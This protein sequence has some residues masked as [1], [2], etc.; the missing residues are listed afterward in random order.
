MTTLRRFAWAFGAIGA[1]LTMGFLARLWL[2]GGIDGR[3]QLLAVAGALA[4][5]L[6]AWL[7][8]ETLQDVAADRSVQLGGGAAL[9]T[10]LAGGVYVAT[11]AAVRQVDQ[12]VDLSRGD[13]RSLRDHS[14]QVA[15]AVDRDL[16]MFGFFPHGSAQQ[17]SFLDL[18]E[19]YR[20]LN[21]RIAVRLVDPLREPRVAEANDVAVEGG[22]VL[23][24]TADREERLGNRYDEAALTNALRRLTVDEDVEVCWSVGH[25]EL[26]VDADRDPDAASFAVVALE[27]QA[28]AVREVSTLSG[29]VPDSCRVF[30]VMGPQTA[31]Q[32]EEAALLQDFLANG[33]RAL[34]AFEPGSDGTA[35]LVDALRPFG[36]EVG[37]DPV[38]DPH[39]ARRLATSEDP[40]VQVLRR[41]AWTPHAISR[42]LAGAVLLRI[43]APVTALE[44]VPGMAT[45]GLLWTSERA[46]VEVDGP[47]EVAP[48]DHETVGSHSVVAVAEVSKPAQVAG[49]QVTSDQ[50]RLVVVG[51]TAFATNRFS[52]FGSSQELFLNT[53]AWLADEDALLG[54]RATNNDQ[55]LAIS[56]AEELML[57]VF[58]V[59]VGPGIALA[60]ALRSRMQRRAPARGRTP[61][62]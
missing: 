51:D 62:P 10:L 14:A 57:G 31:W 53:L 6:Y 33:G 27:G 43:A 26:D 8:G 34:L 17:A 52:E 35:S 9:L 1:A 45:R 41:E 36:I 11:Y 12:F 60:F 13:A 15:R 28:Y 4:L 55:M 38:L 40:S 37:N 48:G 25:G 49:V 20:A 5:V 18:A 21:P 22:I 32:P 29:P 42:S 30:V 7:D 58:A 3:G 23:L 56:L 16:E 44:D 19:R 46:W 59:F 2:F 54:E 24:R 39:P 61:D 47:G 50:M